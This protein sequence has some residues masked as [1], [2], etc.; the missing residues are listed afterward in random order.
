VRI[1]HLSQLLG[2][3]KRWCKKFFSM[4]KCSYS[5]GM[6]KMIVETLIV[7]FHSANFPLVMIWIV[8]DESLSMQMQE[9][10]D[11]SATISR[12]KFDLVKIRNESA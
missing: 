10:T 12:C 4:F 2:T 1:N 8:P 3:Y 11:I 6:E 5:N 7:L 9:Q